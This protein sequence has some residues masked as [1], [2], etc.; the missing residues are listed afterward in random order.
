MTGMDHDAST[1]SNL[2]TSEILAFTV[3]AVGDEA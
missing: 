1:V 3:V 2:P